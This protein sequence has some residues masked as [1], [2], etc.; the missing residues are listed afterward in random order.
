MW[1]KR[2]R[3]VWMG[4]H[5][6]FL[7][8]HC[9]PRLAVTELRARRCA[10]IDVFCQERGDARSLLRQ[11]GGRIEIISPNWRDRYAAISSTPIVIGRR[12]VITNVH[13]PSQRK[14]S[15]DTPH[16]IRGENARPILMI[17]AGAAFGTGEH[18]TTAMCL[19]IL[20]RATRNQPDGWSQL[21]CGT[22]TGILALAGRC[23]GARAILAIDVDPLVILTAKENARSNG[24]RGVRFQVADVT[25]WRTGRR[26]DFI[27][28]NLYSELLI[29]ALPE[30][31]CNLKETG[32]FILSGVLPTQ[33]RTVVRAL[34][35]QGFMPLEIRRRGRWVALFAGR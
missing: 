10:M 29:R 8:S 16:R 7:E 25:N 5:L 31:V 13:Q 12:L 21:D 11:F 3:P 19:R 30:L 17:P 15:D 35:N 4:A 14:R 24:I 2:A 9:G 6:D 18:A 20:E 33:E 28:A 34:R 32:R 1:R 22:G 26:F 27:T 23:F